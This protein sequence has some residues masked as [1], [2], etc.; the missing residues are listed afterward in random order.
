MFKQPLTKRSYSEN[1]MSPSGSLKTCFNLT[2][3]RQEYF[4]TV[5]SL[6]NFNCT[7]QRTVSVTRWN[8]GHNTGVS[9][10]IYELCIW[11]NWCP[12][13]YTNVVFGMEIS[14]I[15]AV[16]RAAFTTERFTLDSTIFKPAVVVLTSRVIVS[17]LQQVKILCFFKFQCVLR[18]WC[19]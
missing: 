19:S 11:S 10:R 15:C 14:G 13:T 1:S 4:A 18:T 3:D 16:G 2:L 8:N 9:D 7:I 12:R 17:F 6:D 5:K